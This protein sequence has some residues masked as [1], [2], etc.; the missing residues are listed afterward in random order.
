MSSNLP[1]V[2][3]QLLGTTPEDISGTTWLLGHDLKS[4]V[5]IIISTLEMVISTHEDEPEMEPTLRLL[6][7]ALVAARREYNML[8]DMLDLARFELNEYQIERHPIDLGELLRE[9]L[10]EESFSLESKNLKLVTQIGDQGL[11]V[12]GDAELFRRVFSA[13]VDNVLKFT[14]KHDILNISASRTGDTI[15]VEYADTGRPVHADFTTA[16]TSRAPHWNK[17]QEGSR[18]SVGMGLPFVNAVIKA[19]NGVFTT[20]SDTSTGYTYF[21]LSV[22]ALE[23]NGAATSHEQ[24]ESN[25]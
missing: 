12:D 16:I 25:G 24:F 18:S 19:H 21:R 20:S 14:T 11:L 10:E 5:A 22:P 3:G 13:L 23:S 17:R 9:T 1:Q 6:R 15:T 8:C 2:T 7:G 4:P